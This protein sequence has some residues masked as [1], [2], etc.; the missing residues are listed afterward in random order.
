MP[1][2]AENDTETKPE[3]P[4]E[5][6]RREL[7]ALIFEATLCGNPTVLKEAQRLITNFAPVEIARLREECR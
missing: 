7:M 1:K 2:I 3:T 5:I 4:I 6:Y